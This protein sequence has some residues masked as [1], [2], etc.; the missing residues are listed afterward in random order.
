MKKINWTKVLPHVIVLALLLIISVI[1]FYPAFNNSLDTHDISMHKGMSKEIMD[2]RAKEGTEPLWTN[3]MF[4]GMP[5]DQ[6]S[7]SYDSNLMHY[8]YK[9]ITLGLPRP[10]STLWMLL[11]GFYILLMCLKID[12]WVAFIGAVGFGFSTFFMWSMQAGHMSKVNAISFM[13]PVIGSFI[14]LFRGNA[15]KGGVLFSFFL[16][17]Q[18]W[19]GHP[20][21]TYYTFLILLFIGLYFVGELV[22]RKQFSSLVKR[23][24]I[25]GVALLLGVSTSLPSLWG[26]YEYS[27]HTIRGEK[28]LTLPKPNAG[29]LEN[30]VDQRDGLDTDYILA[31]SYGTGETFTFIFPSLKGGGNNDPRLKN[32]KTLFP[33]AAEGLTENMSTDLSSLQIDEILLQNGIN[34]AELPS[35]E[36]RGYYGQQGLTNGPVFVGMILCLLTLL[37]LVFSDGKLNWVLFGATLLTIILAYLQMTSLVLLM[38]VALIIL[39]I[40]N[41]R[42]IWALLTVTML[43]VMLAWGKNYL[44]FSKFFIES[45]PMYSKFRAVT[46]IMVIS[47]LLIPLMGVLFLSQAIKNR[48][49]LAGENL[50]KLYIGCGVIGLGTLVVWLN[51]ELIFNV[52]TELSGT[53][54]MYYDYL[55]EGLSESPQLKPFI[56]ELNQYFIDYAENLHDFRVGI[57]KTDAIK[58]FAFVLVV[59][60][61]LFFYAKEKIQKPVVLVGFSLIVLIEMI[62]VDLKYLNSE[63]DE[64]GDFNYWVPKDKEKAPFSVLPGDLEIYNLEVSEHPWIADSVK[65]ELLSINNSSDQI[66]DGEAQNML[67]FSVLNRLTNF[68]VANFQGLTSESRTSFFYKSLGG[69]HGAK[70]RRIQDIF[71]FSSELDMPKIINMMNVKYMVQYKNDNN[72]EIV[73]MNYSPNPDALGNAWIVNKIKWVNTADDELMSMKSGGDFDPAN[74]A[75]VDQTFA[76]IIGD[77]VSK[78]EDASIALTSYQPNKLVYNFN[79]SSDEVAI[80]SEIYYPHGWTA[81]IDGEPAEIFRANYLL[82]GLSI[83]QGEHTIIFEYKTKSF[84][85]GSTIA[86]I[87]SALILLLLIVLGYLVYKNHK[88]VAEEEEFVLEL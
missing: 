64:A 79:S 84:A 24:I 21:I 66:L 58:A 1:Y 49:L 23:F 39:S 38:F 62:S 15:L 74:E 42:L 56:P 12:P 69:Y 73:G 2:F 55:K 85:V 75:I 60:G 34:L 48:A 77:N 9:I 19:A 65:A 46:M 30:T 26:T 40:V 67:K 3:S 76:G 81:T 50:M 27:K 18:L 52:P 11:L 68:R 53:G 36:E 8:V 37:A 61:L 83:P 78:S 28:F 51:P 54:G 25:G 71:D 13:A 10:V 6:I 32:L 20:Q 57:I 41:K 87:G 88:M 70:L 45:F 86:F 80:F 4:G 29:E 59:F 72:N 7:I 47:D 43:A 33:S 35:N 82:R 63:K 31:W 14:L 17:M 44:S 22:F 16:A 5:A